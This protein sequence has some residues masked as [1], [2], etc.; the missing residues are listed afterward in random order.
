MR[1]IDKKRNNREK[2]NNLH[3]KIVLALFR[4]KQKKNGMDILVNAFAKGVKN[5]QNPSIR[6]Q[7]PK[8]IETLIIIYY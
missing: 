5:E 1:N 7:K 2:K 3:G 4:M 8:Y 6:T